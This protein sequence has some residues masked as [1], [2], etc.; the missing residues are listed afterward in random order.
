MDS[1]F[2]VALVIAMIMGLID[3]L[4]KL[5]NGTSSF[6]RG[7]GEGMAGRGKYR[8]GTYFVFRGRHSGWGIG[9]RIDG[10]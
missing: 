2:G 3:G 1:L 4:I 6:W 8:G 7:F 10:D 9:T 5:N